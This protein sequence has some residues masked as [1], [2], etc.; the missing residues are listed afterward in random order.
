MVLAG[1][2]PLTAGVRCH[3]AQ[4][5][6]VLLK[7]QKATHMHL[8]S[9]RSKLAEAT[10]F[11]MVFTLSHIMTPFFFFLILWKALSHSEQR[12]HFRFALKQ[13]IRQH[14][15]FLLAKMSADL[16]IKRFCNCKENHRGG[17]FAASCYF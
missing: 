7:L 10:V 2:V 6:D 16:I 17:H 9:W 15:I 11:H 8:L 13:K 12:A 14:F 4:A 3:F 1:P 5:G